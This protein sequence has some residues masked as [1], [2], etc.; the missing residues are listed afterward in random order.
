MLKRNI[1]EC[2]DSLKEEHLLNL[3]NNSYNYLT[4]VYY[5]D[6][7]SECEHV[8]D[9]IINVSESLAEQHS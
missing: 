1:N 3:E 9:Y 5:I 2:R 8:G 6:L 4:G 7:V